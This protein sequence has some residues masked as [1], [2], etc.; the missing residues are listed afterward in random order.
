MRWP[1]QLK[2]RRRRH[3]V[4]RRRKSQARAQGASGRKRKTGGQNKNQARQRRKHKRT[5]KEERRQRCKQ[6]EDKTEGGN[7]R[8]SKGEAEVGE[9]GDKATLTGEGNRNIGEED[10]GQEKAGQER[11]VRTEGDQI[12]GDGGNDT[13]GA[14]PPGGTTRMMPTPDEAEWASEVWDTVQSKEEAE[15]ILQKFKELHGEAMS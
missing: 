1:A 9:R 12:T 7:A 6:E 8:G 5:R 3:R 13:D 10:E 2:G 14:Q 4:K 11:K 15:E